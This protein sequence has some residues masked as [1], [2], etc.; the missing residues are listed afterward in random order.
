[1]NTNFSA[2]SPGI[3]TDTLSGDFIIYQPENGQRYTTDDFLV[4]WFSITILQESLRPVAS[5]LDLGSGLCSVPMIILWAFPALTGAG[6]EI[7]RDRLS[8]GMKSLAANRLSQR[9]HLIQGDTRRISLKKRS[10]V[11][12]SNV[13]KEMKERI[14]NDSLKIKP[15]MLGERHAY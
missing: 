15:L 6:I 10:S 14:L 12:K 11:F 8:L 3:Q 9:F 7:N 2:I 5:F 13:F 1:M 4:G